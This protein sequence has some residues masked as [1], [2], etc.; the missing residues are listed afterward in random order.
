MPYTVADIARLTGGEITG[1]ASLVLNGFAPADRSQPGDLTFAE[2]ANYFARAEQSAASAILVDSAYTSRGKTLIRVPN[3]RVAFAKVLPLF[4]PETP[5]APGIHPTALVPASAQVDPTAHIGPYCVLGEQVRIGARSV[6]QGLNHIG[7]NC[8][9]GEEVN[10]FPNVTL[11]PRTEVGHRVRIHAGT[12]VGADGFGYVLDNG[13]HRKVPQ[14]GN[15]I[16][17]DDVE[18]GANVTVDR[19]AL[20]PTFIGR[21]TKVDN[22]VQIAH[23]VTLGEHCII[24]SQVGIS[25]STRLGNYVVLGGQVGLAGHLRIGNRVAVAAQSGVMHN[26]PDGEKWLWTPAQPDRQAKRQMIALQQ[27]PEL[28]RRVKELEKRLEAMGE[29][30]AA[31]PPPTS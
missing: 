6:L 14:I 24:V 8:V 11:Y 17:C 23:N 25:G 15:V 26:I 16:I 30:P 5:F 22:L 4:F 29:P 2:N 3:A 18:L 1:D 12:V 31:D 9:L 20:G 7:A 28:L 13:V 10:L 27:L 19:G 21:G